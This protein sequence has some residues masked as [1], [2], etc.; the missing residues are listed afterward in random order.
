[1]EFLTG[2]GREHSLGAADRSPSTARGIWTVTGRTRNT[3]P[4]GMSR[5]ARRPTMSAR[6]PPGSLEES[7]L[8]EG[9]CEAAGSATPWDSG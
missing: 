5:I 2:T 7:R 3:R 9:A 4:D 8:N 1:M 6:H